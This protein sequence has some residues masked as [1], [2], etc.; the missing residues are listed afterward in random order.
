MESCLTL[1]R[2]YYGAKTDEITEFIDTHPTQ[3]KPRLL[4]KILSQMMIKCNGEI[5][6]EQ[7]D[8]LQEYKA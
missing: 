4:S 3:D 6:D 8:I 5:T 1:V 7:I 2:S